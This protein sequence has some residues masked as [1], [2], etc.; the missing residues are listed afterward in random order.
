MGLGDEMVSRARAE[1]AQLPAS[2]LSG[3]GLDALRAEAS[4]LFARLPESPAYRRACDPSRERAGELLPKATELL[5]RAFAAQSIAPEESRASLLARALEAHVR[6]L[7]AIAAGEI[8]LG[9]DHAREASALARELA[10]AGSLFAHR[11]QATAKAYDPETGTSRYDPSP[12]QALTVQLYC[13]NQGCRRPA[14][15][16]ISPRHATHRLVCSLCRKPFTGHFAELR[17]AEARSTGTAM[18]YALRTFPLGGGEATLEFDDTSGGELAVAP[19]DLLVLLYAGTGSLAAVENL[20]SGHVLWTSPKG[21]CFLATAV[22]G[23]GAAELED[24]RRFRDRV[25]L[26]RA[27]GRAL[28]RL[29]YGVG[30][31][32]ARATGRH[33]WFGWLARQLLDRLRKHLVPIPL[34]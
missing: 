12:E 20:T 30:P 1:A 16:Q 32:L 26:P 4:A 23:E 27:G 6:A 7:A 14:A 28:V 18:H 19:G 25:L 15:Y 34:P 5:G 3:P 33:P 22:Y 31:S 10:K 13:P 8:T 11:P 24:F 9:D 29:Y 2:S 17:A 21:A